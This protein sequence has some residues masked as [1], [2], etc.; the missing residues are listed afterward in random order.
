ML[1]IDEVVIRKVQLHRLEYAVSQFLTSGEGDSEALVKC[2]NHLASNSSQ[3]HFDSADIATIKKLKSSS[4]SIRKSNRTNDKGN[5][6]NDSEVAQVSLLEG[7]STEMNRKSPYSVN[8]IEAKNLSNRNNNAQ[9]AQASQKSKP[10]SFFS[11]V[12]SAEN[13][14][15]LLQ[16]QKANSAK[17]LEYEQ[18]TQQ[19]LMN[20]LAE[21]TGILKDSTLQINR[22]VLEQN[23]QLT[24]I[25][26]FASENH[27]ELDYQKKQLNERSKEMKSSLWSSVLL[28]CIVFT[29]FSVTYLIIRIFP[30][31]SSSF[32]CPNRTI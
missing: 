5:E 2:I 22:S 14:Q 8:N 27:T 16:D 28:I 15:A 30:K 7:T 6:L 17:E 31:P 19:E 9:I 26:H 10:K 11:D 1:E 21:L 4:K 32:T 13:I 24:S 12:V 25:H 3:R 18:K 23:E 29:I 20:D